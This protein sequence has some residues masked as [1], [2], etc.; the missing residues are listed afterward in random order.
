MN[1][2]NELSFLV[3]AD[4]A[5]FSDPATRVGG[6]K[7]SY[8]V[9][10]YQALVGI[11][12]S[13]YW[14]PTFKWVI[15]AVRIMKP[16]QTQSKGIRPIRYSG[17]NDLSIYTYLSDVAYQ[18]KLHFEWNENRP[19]LEK[20]RNEDKHYQIAKR[21]IQRG[22]RRD[23]FLGTRE[24]QGYIEP[25]SF[26]EGTGAYD[27][28]AELSFGFMVHGINYPDMTSRKT[29]EVRLWTPIMRK[30]VIEFCRTE[31][32]PLVRTIRP[33]GMKGFTPG[34]NFT[35]CEEGSAA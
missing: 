15:D 31:D 16:I 27:D 19:E 12:E 22:G 24:C 18:V 13:C 25:C 23:I 14:K 17:G 10:T 8:M 32:C 2:E 28:L 33:M 30:G 34:E 5:L 3:Y 6:E 29:M 1:Y 21:M 4:F 20:D 7:S 9:P 11:A 26:G 35:Y